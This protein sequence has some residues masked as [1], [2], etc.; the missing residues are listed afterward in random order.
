MLHRHSLFSLLAA[1]A[2]FAISFTSPAEASSPLDPQTD[3]VTQTNW[4]WYGNTTVQTIQNR[5]SQGYRVVDIEV[6]NASPLR[7]SASLVRNTGDYA[8]GWWWYY[9]ATSAQVTSLL[10]QNGARAIDI[11]PYDTAN[12][13]RYAVVMIQNTGSDFATSHGWQFGFTFTNLVDWRAA[14]PNRRIIDVQPYLIGGSR[15]YAFC[16]VANT[17]QTQSASWIYLNTTNDFIRDRLADNQARLI[18]LEPHDDTGRFSAIMVP[19]DGNLWAWFTNMQFADVSR[20]AGQ[21]ASRIIDIQRY[22][23]TS[24]ATRYAMVIRRNDNDLAVTTTAQMRNGL[25][26]SATSGFMLREYQGADST[27]AG[28]F[29]NRVF[30]PASLIKTVHHFVA[31][32]R[33]RQ[34]LDSFASPV[35]ENTGTNGSCPNGSNPTTR[36]LG[37]VLRSMMEQSSNTATEAVRNR[38]GTNTIESIAASYGATDVELNHTI[39]CLCG[40]TRNELTLG[41]LASLHGAV[42]DGALGS[43]REDFYDRMSNGTNFGMGSF[44]TATVLTS[45]LAASSLSAAERNAFLAGT[46]FAHKG[47]SYT[48]NF[49]GNVE[50]HRSR[51]AYVRFPVRSGCG[52]NYAEYFIGAWV[53]DADTAA[54]AANAVGVGIVTLFRDRLRA[55]LAT[56]E[57]ANCNAFQNYCT[58]EFNSS[59]ARGTIV[60]TGTPYILENNLTM[61]GASM[62][63][64][65]FA[66]IIF[67]D[68]AAFVPNPGGS[69]GN[70]CVG[71]AI[72]RLFG[73]LGTTSATGTLTYGINNRTLSTSAGGPFQLIPGDRLMFQW[74][75][76]DFDPA[77]PTSNF[78]NAVQVT[79]I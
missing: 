66:S 60:A 55:A 54:Q 10:N 21:Y 26:F 2:A 40:Q 35:S 75:F 22:A 41:D 31:N 74:W 67:G 59:G 34:N 48:C 53:N 12:G 69:A 51:G 7:M 8:K 33:V 44:S 77:G 1:L 18:D 45:E 32:R 57:D 30:E 28:V 61:R 58:A 14:N 16:W 38:Y 4:A 76:R 39:G 9:D 5:I 23:T 70:L 42:I 36:S 46:Y 68:T 11:E 15:R 13:I 56:W 6:E 64:G 20:L 29:E 24:G 78:T 19:R 25:P 37:T 72:G 71:G 17:G 50:E 3:V 43:V 73:S 49:G 63:A 52:T 27:V 62:P 65:S 47:G 79:F